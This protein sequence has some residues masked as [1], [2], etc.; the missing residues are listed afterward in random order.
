VKALLTNLTAG[1]RDLVRETERERMAELDEDALVELHRRIR[2]A[3]NKYVG[4]YRREAAGRVRDVGGR[5]AARP[6][7]RRNAGRAEIFEDALARV[8]RRLALVAKQSAADLKAERLAAARADAEEARAAKAAGRAAVAVAGTGPASAGAV[9]G[10]G[11]TPRATR[12]PARRKRDAS[13]LAAG[14]RRQ[15]GRDSR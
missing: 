2:R 5:G 4:L 14:A 3:R 6:K 13:S 7:N 8:S 12:P 1:E 15:A 9:T 10:S 11:R